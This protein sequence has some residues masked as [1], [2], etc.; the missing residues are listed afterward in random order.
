[1]K[2]HWKTVDSEII[3]SECHHDPT[4]WCEIILSQ[5]SNPEHVE[6]LKKSDEPTYDTSVEGSWPGDHNS[7]KSP[8][9]DILMWN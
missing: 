9:S 4:S 6:F 5:T 3:D 7:W 1:M 2:H 8:W